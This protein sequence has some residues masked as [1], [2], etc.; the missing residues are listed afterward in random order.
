MIRERRSG[1]I[2]SLNWLDREHTSERAR[3]EAGCGRRSPAVNGN[4]FR[5]RRSVAD[6]RDA[7]HNL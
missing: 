7:Q 1:V 2:R 6:Y 3:N 5:L 4:N